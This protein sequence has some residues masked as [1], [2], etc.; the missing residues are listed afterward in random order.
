M[1]V[2]NPNPPTPQQIIAGQ[3][4]FYGWRT[5]NRG[6]PGSSFDRYHISMIT[7]EGLR[8]VGKNTVVVDSNGEEVNIINIFL[9]EKEAREH[10]P[11]DEEF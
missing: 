8:V 3:L 7:A 5:T 6:G 4:Y 2:V 10:C 1:H 11:Q 9:T